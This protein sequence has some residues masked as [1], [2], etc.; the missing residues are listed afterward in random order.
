MIAARSSSSGRW[1]ASRKG[2]NVRVTTGARLPH[3]LPQRGFALIALLAVL[4][5]GMLYFLVGQLDAGAMQRR[6][7]EATTRALAQAKEALIA[8]AVSVNLNGGDDRPGDLPCPDLDD[9][10]I[11]ESKE[12]PPKFCGDKV[13]SN[14]Q[15]RLGRLPWHTLGLPDLRDGSGERLWYAVSNN[16]KEKSR[17]DFL[18]SDTLGTITVRDNTGNL[19]HDG[20]GTT[21]VVAVIIA[22]GPPITRQDGL[23]QDRSGTT[24]NNPR[25]YLD[26]IAAEDNADFDEVVNKTNGFFSGPV[27]NTNGEIVANDRLIV[28]TRDEIMAAVEKR[29]AAEVTHCL[30]DYA[31]QPQNNGHLPWPASLA[32]SAGGNYAGVSGSLFGRLPDSFADTVTDST[33]PPPPPPALPPMLSNWTGT[34]MINSGNLWFNNWREVVFF[35]IANGFKPA[36]PSVAAA[37]GACITVNRTGLALTNRSL[38]VLVAGRALP[39]LTRTT[40][41]EKGNVANYLE[42]EN[43]TPGDSIF[44]MGTT[45]STFNDRL[46]YSPQ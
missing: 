43:S 14:P 38:V 37:C 41:A 4:A 35:A 1:L 21:G 27:R 7:D 40:V 42:L 25:H 45:T 28:I 8:Y 39:G 3:A 30:E 29:V 33:C 44:E 34:C 24:I 6:Q 26:N 10:G 20:S 18:N 17:T 11:A 2:R 5:T 22:P 19:I 23:Q 36:C 13:G 46:R 12:A 16:F 32:N 31:A 9:N 15:K